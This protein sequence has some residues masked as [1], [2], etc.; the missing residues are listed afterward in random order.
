MKILFKIMLSYDFFEL[1]HLGVA[2]RREAG[3][4]ARRELYRLNAEES[5]RAA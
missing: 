5:Y 2:V 3:E 1:G 4:S